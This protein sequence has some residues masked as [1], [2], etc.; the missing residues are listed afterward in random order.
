MIVSYKFRH[1]LL[2]FSFLF[3]K[4]CYAQ[5]IETIE[6]K[7]LIFLEKEFLSQKIKTLPT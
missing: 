2:L 1:I 4:P 7:F 6:N 3:F 5:N